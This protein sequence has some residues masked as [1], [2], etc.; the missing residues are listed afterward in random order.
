MGIYRTEGITSVLSG[1]T[2]RP[3]AASNPAAFTQ[4]LLTAQTASTTP[5]S[6]GSQ[7]SLAELQQNYDKALAAARASG[8]LPYGPYIPGREPGAP[9]GPKVP[10]AVT[11]AWNKLH[12]GQAPATGTPPVAPPPL[13]GLTGPVDPVFATLWTN[14]AGDTDPAKSKQNQVIEAVSAAQLWSDEAKRRQGLAAQAQQDAEAAKAQYGENS[15][16]YWAAA[17]RADAA[18]AAVRQAEA[19]AVQADAQFNVYATDPSY[20]SAMN[21][22]TAAFNA[23]L[24]PPQPLV[25]TGHGSQAD[26][27]AQL[28]KANQNVQ[29]ANQAV[30]K[31]QDAATEFSQLPDKYNP[32]LPYW[33]PTAMITSTDYHGP[34]LET[35]NKQRR[36][37]YNHN[38]SLYATKTWRTAIGSQQTSRLSC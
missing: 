14:A 38:Q 21:G 20:A 10:Q 30:Q 19:N 6:P 18:L 9:D 15:P 23:G 28:A 5:G 13:T 7:P 32:S 37:A 34:S 4:A 17:A 27:Q 2:Y 16:Q 26:A 33:E 24:N 31:Y 3:L 8:Q 25:L 1:N 11:D 36:A 29:E 12:A 22:A 35:L